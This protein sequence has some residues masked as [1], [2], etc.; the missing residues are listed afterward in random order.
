MD[1]DDFLSIL[2]TPG[3]DVDGIVERLYTA[4]SAPASCRNCEPNHLR[5]NGRGISAPIKN[6]STTLPYRSRASPET[7]QSLGKDDDEID[8]Y[9]GI[10]V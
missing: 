2:E 7:P 8:P 6:H 4:T 1:L 10:Y 5:S 9:G 3:V